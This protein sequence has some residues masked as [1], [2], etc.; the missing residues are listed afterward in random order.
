MTEPDPDPVP[1]SVLFSL[2]SS[3]GNPRLDAAKFKKSLTQLAVNTA[4]YFHPFGV[5]GLV[6]P[7]DTW[8]ALNLGVPTPRPVII[9]P[10]FNPGAAAAA[11]ATYNNDLK[12]YYKIIKDLASVREAIILSLPEYIV[13]TLE[14][15]VLGI[16]LVTAFQLVQAAYLELGAVHTTD[17]EEVRLQ[18][19]NPIE[20]PFDV[21]LSDFM[22]RCVF[23]A[24]NDDT[25]SPVEM[26]RLL[27][28]SLKNNYLWMYGLYDSMNS[29]HYLLI[30]PTPT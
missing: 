12:E 29:F 14:D 27:I 1:V 5:S 18:L 10:I 9:R 19:E 2:R 26:N 3:L 8:L 22:E 24:S 7:D 13:K 28:K 23:L 20:S 21:H 17:F 16:A 30:A 25:V 4:Q 11:M 6:L 15:P